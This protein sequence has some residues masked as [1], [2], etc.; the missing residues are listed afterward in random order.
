MES[1]LR[2]KDRSRD[3]SLPKG[4]QV[5]DEALE[6][7]AGILGSLPRRR[8]LLIEALHLIQ[9]HDGHLSAANLA[10]LAELFRLAQ[11][12]VYEVASFY[13]HFDVVREGETPPPPVTIRVCDGLS[14]EMAG[15]KGLI[16]SLRAEIDPAR[17]RVQ[18]VP[19][20]GGCDMA[21]AAQC[22]K[23]S[24]GRASAAA[25]LRAA[26]DPQ[27]PVI[28]DYQGLEAY[29]Y[30]GGYA[31][32]KR[33]LSGDISAET[34]IEVMSDAQLRGLGGAGFPAGRK[35]SLVR[36]ENGPR[37]MTV[38]GDEGEPGTFKD[39]YWLEREPHRL[40]E[41]ALIA[42]HV[43][44]C[45]R[46]YIYMRDEY[47]AVREILAREIDALEAAGLLSTPME[48][49][50]G[51]G[52]YICGEESAMI[53]SIEGKR[54]LP[55]HRPPYIAQVGLFGRPTLNHNV[56][57]L[58]WV[59]DI[60]QNGAKWFADQGQD[61]AHSGLRSFS[62]SGRV[63]EP[64]VKLAPAGIPLNTLIAEHCGGMAD[65]HEFRAF[66]PGGASG[67]VFPASMA[68][69]PLNFGVF[70]PYGGF[71]GSHAIV[72]LSQQDR[73]ADAVLNTMRFFRDESCGQCTPC[74][75]GTDK[76]VRLLEAGNADPALLDDL[77]LV[78]RDSSIC[79]LG[80][81]ASN[82]VRHLLKYFPEETS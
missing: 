7:V 22:G 57:T 37:L 29:R 5:G 69:L 8:D 80:Q 34:A 76:I 31:S 67:G 48:L 2:R 51:A 71:I 65:G 12:E 10:A 54:G 24:V 73:V 16:E 45:D 63:K 68:D 42:A 38:N 74:R 18:A 53:E 40:L 26:A 19:C 60:L 75:S 50:R 20:I 36:A 27:E 77:G 46:I 39:R 13:H 44:G 82:C 15:A 43:V 58:S 41:G 66:L 52:A 59:A 23:R 49:R 55:R 6:H 79:G 62:V 72:I 11:A 4:R 61:E 9:D 33:V 35:W 3:P 25:L 78:M 64:G 30:A 56:E 32:L 17:I 28:P 1:S 70:E 14:C 21:P 47:P 81:A